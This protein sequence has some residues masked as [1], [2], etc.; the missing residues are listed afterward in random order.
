LTVYVIP[1]GKKKKLRPHTFSLLNPSP[2]KKNRERE[3]GGK[4]RRG[5]SKWEKTQAPINLL[6][7]LLSSRGGKEGKDHA[8]RGRKGR[9]GRERSAG[10]FEPIL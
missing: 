6:L 7:L 9:G 2:K 1:K 8:Q 3:E 5:K 10:P 4:K